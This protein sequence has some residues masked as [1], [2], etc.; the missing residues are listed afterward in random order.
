MEKNT[1]FFLLLVGAHSKLYRI[2]AIDVKK[3][4][5]VVTSKSFL[6]G[7]FTKVN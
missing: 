7:E 2:P 6:F 4:L 3:S 1:S 5:G